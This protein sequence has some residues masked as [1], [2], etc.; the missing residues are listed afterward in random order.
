MVRPLLPVLGVPPYELPPPWLALRSGRST[1]GR[2]P[3]HAP[4][5]AG[6]RKFILTGSMAPAQELHGQRPL[7][8]GHT[9]GWP[10]R[11][12]FPTPSPPDRALA[13]ASSHEHP[14]STASA[15][16]CSFPLE[17]LRSSSDPSS[18]LHFSS[19]HRCFSPWLKLAR[20]HGTYAL[21]CKRL[22]RFISV[23]APSGQRPYF[24]S[25]S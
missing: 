25:P 10:W 5:R 23:S 3:P 6:Q 2:R 22:P 13:P 11:P 7:L 15:S 24:T 17:V 1:H 9:V 4:E 14:F 21:L 18:P 12:E 20:P 16:L 8:L 19:C